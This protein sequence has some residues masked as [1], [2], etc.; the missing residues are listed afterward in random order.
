MYYLASVFMALIGCLA[1]TFTDQHPEIGI[2][3]ILGFMSSAFY[4]DLYKNEKQKHIRSNADE[5][6][7]E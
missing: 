5:D 2:M 6:R 4:Y 3:A 7:P 1:L